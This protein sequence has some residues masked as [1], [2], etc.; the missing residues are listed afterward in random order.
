MGKYVIFAFNGNPMCFVHVLLNALDLD[1]K[2]HEAHIVVEGE[3]VK[4]IQEMEEGKNPLY[5]KAKDKGLF[6]GICKA[7]SAKLKVLDYN[8]TTG[9]PL[10]GDMM[11]HPSMEAYLS[12]GFEMITL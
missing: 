5:K 1:E 12:K 8:Q 2:G 9:I 3:A 11:G 6:D 7:C 10:V 4:V